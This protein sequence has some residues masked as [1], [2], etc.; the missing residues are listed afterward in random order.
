LKFVEKNETRVRAGT[1][2]GNWKLQHNNSIQEFLPDC[3]EH[4]ELDCATHTTTKLQ[5]NCFAT[6]GRLRN[7]TPRKLN[8]PFFSRVGCLVSSLCVIYCI[9]QTVWKVDEASNS[10]FVQLIEL[11]PGLNIHSDYAWRDKVDLVWERISHEM[12]ERGRY[13]FFWL[14]FIIKLKI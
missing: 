6:L 3:T 9:V 10:A 12:K 13:I 14:K 7:L 1:H 8:K 5:H 4:M 2:Q 11:E